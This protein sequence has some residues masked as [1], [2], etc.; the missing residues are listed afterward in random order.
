MVERE[1]EGVMTLSQEVAARRGKARLSRSERSPVL[2]LSCNRAPTLA[3]FS[4]HINSPP[5]DK[6]D[7]A[8]LYT[9]KHTRLACIYSGRNRN[10]VVLF[11]NKF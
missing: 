5:R 4:R 7:I 3:S 8:R 9:I 1:T 2:R 11:F 6:V 10:S